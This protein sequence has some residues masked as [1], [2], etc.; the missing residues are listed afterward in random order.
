MS[1]VRDLFPYESLAFLGKVN[2][3]ISH[4]LKNIMAIISETAG[5]LEDLS[6]MAADGPP[7]A[8]DMLANCTRSIVEEIQRGFATIRQMNRLAHSVDTPVAT[9]DLLE[10]IDLVVHLA[11]YLSRSGKVRVTAVGKASPVVRT[12]P[13]L[14]QAIIYQVLGYTFENFGAGADLTISILPRDDSVWRIVFSGFSAAGFRV[15]PDAAT[16]RMAD[17]IQVRI[18]WETTADQLTLDVPQRLAGADGLASGTDVNAVTGSIGD[19]NR[20]E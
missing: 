19:N 14:L 16:R 1:D 13:F 9:V 11:G 3:S 7:V 6:D 12:S 2:A 5:L 20:Q 17:A 4:E 8:P 10:L 18:D 15:F